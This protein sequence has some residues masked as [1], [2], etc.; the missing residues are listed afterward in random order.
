MSIKILPKEIIKQ[1]AAGE[2]IDRPSAVIKE[3]IENSID[4]LSS[5]INIFIEKGGVKLIKINDNG[6]G[7]S[8]DDLL[9]CL[10][11]YA[12]S[13]IKNLDDLESFKSFGF[14]G[15]AL[16]SIKNISR[17]KI[18]SKTVC[19]KTAWE[20]YTEGMDS[21]I[22]YIKPSPNSVG[23]TIEVLD[24]F[25]NMPVRRKFIPNN[26]IEFIYIKNI[27]KSFILMKL[28]IGIK[29]IYNN[30]VI[31]NFPKV[32]NNISYINRINKICGKDFINQSLKINSNDYKMSL[33]GWITIPESKYYSNNIKKYFYINNRLINNKFINH[34]IKEICKIK[35]G[36]YYHQSFLIYLEIEPNKIDINVHPQKKDVNFF[37]LELIYNFF[38]KSIL[39]SSLYF[40]N[41]KIFFNQN[42]KNTDVV[43]KKN[44]K[45]IDNYYNNN[46]FNKINKK[47]LVILKNI[48]L[49]HFKNFGILRT[50]IKNTWIIVEKNDILFYL[51]VKEIEF[52]LLKIK[53][54]FYLENQNNIEI[55]F[56]NLQIKLIQKELDIFNRLKKILKIL[57]FNF[58]INKFNKYQLRLISIPS[59]LENF[60]IQSFFI[61][62][63]KY[64]LIKNNITF[65]KILKWIFTYIINITKLWDYFKTIDLLMELE[66]FILNNNTIIIKKLFYPINFNNILYE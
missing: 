10:K 8:K 32:E 50:I 66:L 20:I 26:K 40:T 47:K 18:I 60:D 61:N 9:L 15:E 56:L 6:I 44:K 48:P 39:N 57:G 59:L 53:Y 5:Q 45:N 58:V 4:A 54:K 3:L 49:F 62:L 19:Q 11:K 64:C 63:F 21:N 17:I 25:Y 35:F 29:F 37:Q 65:K 43:I 23:T 22:T 33:F 1:I 14:R 30:K 52:L 2:V 34:I 42:K 41:K 51:S 31:Y 55:I 12:T 46:F 24:L 27:I 36:C 7:M 28:N 38:Y 16:T 13:K